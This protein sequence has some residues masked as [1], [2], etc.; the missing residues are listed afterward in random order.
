MY[1][2][3]QAATSLQKPKAVADAVYHAISSETLGNPNRGGHNASIQSSRIIYETR[4]AIQKLFHAQ[5]YH[6]VLTKNAT[7][8]INIALKGLFKKGE[9]LITTVMEHNSVLRPL[10][11]LEDKGLALDFVACDKSSGQLLYNQFE[12][13]LSEQTKAVVVTCA[14][15]VTGNVTNLKWISDFCKKHQLKLIVDGASTAGIIDINLDELE[16]D[17]FCFT[18]HKSL[19]GPQG[20]GGM[21]I[22]KGT[23][24]KPLTTGGS[25]F[26]TFSKEHPAELPESLEA[27]TMNVHGFAGLCA[28]IQYILDQS[29][30]KLHHHVK[31][32]MMY[33]YEN[34]KHLDEIKIYGDPTQINTGIVALNVGKY[35]SAEISET[36][37]ERFQI[38]TRPGS[39]CAPL[40]HQQLGT[41]DQGVVRF[42]FS[43]FHT[44]G[45]V[46]YA[47]DAIEQLVKEY[48]SSF[49]T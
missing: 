44:M 26:A 36:L 34:T 24:I 5:N 23:K 35:D 37:D 31:E 32:L 48:K 2:F 17:I 9:H 16:I 12:L 1:Y 10:Y 19:Y 49:F 38:L 27:G 4:E 30:T 28:G 13:L 29:V 39:H 7:E 11:E 33:F 8:A 42:S 41:V 18:G 40:M 21:C 3:D 46:K 20:T 45:D 14:S 43:P 6:V 15:N 22:K 47:A 25:G